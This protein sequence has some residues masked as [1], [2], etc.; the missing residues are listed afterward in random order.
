MTCDLEY[1]RHSEPL[2]EARQL[3]EEAIDN[4][5]SLDSDEVTADIS[6]ACV[7]MYEALEA[8]LTAKRKASK[9]GMASSVVKHSLDY[10][11]EPNLNL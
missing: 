10:M 6:K 1:D 4:L 11:P 7:L 9:L 3:I 8:L 5:E 2:T